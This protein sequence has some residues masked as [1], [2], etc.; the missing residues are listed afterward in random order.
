MNT[1][2]E[3]HLESAPEPKDSSP[4]WMGLLLAL[5]ILITTYGIASGLQ[6][7]GDENLP[8]TS[9]GVSDFFTVI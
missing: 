7:K 1:T 3:E 8:F 2:E 9:Q 4:P 5:G 6:I